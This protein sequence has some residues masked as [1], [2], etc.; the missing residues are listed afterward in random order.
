MI[1][2]QSLTGDLGTVLIKK[3]AIL[4]TLQKHFPKSTICAHLWLL[5]LEGH[6][7][8]VALLP[9][10]ILILGCYAL[11]GVLFQAQVPGKKPP[12]HQVV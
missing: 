11:N 7:H 12:L 2:M 6:Q 4:L 1:T 9:N 5:L 3:S 8:L 10:I